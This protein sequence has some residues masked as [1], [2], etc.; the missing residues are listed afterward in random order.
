MCHSHLLTP[1]RAEVP[2]VRRW[3]FRSWVSTL[4]TVVASALNQVP[5]LWM[6]W[7]GCL[8]VTQNRL[9]FPKNFQHWAGEGK[10]WSGEWA[11]I[12]ADASIA[13][14]LGTWNNLCLA[15]GC[16]C[17]QSGFFCTLLRLN[18]HLSL[19]FFQS[20]VLPVLLIADRIVLSQPSQSLAFLVTWKLHITWTV[21]SITALEY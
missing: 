7:R 21:T 3:C 1:G 17:S 2:H 11:R 19:C 12:P 9:G 16:K 4:A 15:C 14:C 10:P 13:C 20:L 18:L 5:S 6:L 8:K